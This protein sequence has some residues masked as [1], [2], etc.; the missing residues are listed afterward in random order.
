MFDLYINM[1]VGLSRLNG[2]NLYHATFIQRVIGNDGKPLEI[3]TSNPI[4]DTRIYEVYYIYV[5]VKTLASDVIAENLLSQV[6]QE[7]HHYLLIDEIIDHRKTPESVEQKDAF[8]STHNGNLKWQETTKG[9][10]LCFQWK[11]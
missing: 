4:T 2:D 5:T 8:D 1:E 9:W 7:G 3:G 6:D 11:C 10:E